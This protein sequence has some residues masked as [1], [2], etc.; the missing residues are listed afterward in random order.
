MG[1]RGL[2]ISDPH[3]MLKGTTRRL[4]SSQ[5][6]VGCHIHA[7][8]HERAICVVQVHMTLRV[9]DNHVVLARVGDSSINIRHIQFSRAAQSYET[10]RCS[11]K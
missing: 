6:Q 9:T 7:T 2:R 10:A 5:M 11:T 3:A 4:D 1:L 8:R